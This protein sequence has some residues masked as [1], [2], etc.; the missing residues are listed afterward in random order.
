M[1]HYLIFFGGVFLGVLM[2]FIIAC[3]CAMA[4]EKESD[5][6]RWERLRKEMEVEE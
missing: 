5:V 6:E 4:H 1:T 3:L 2:G